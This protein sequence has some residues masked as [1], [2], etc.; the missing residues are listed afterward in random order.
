MAVYLW[1]PDDSPVSSVNP[2][3]KQGILGSCF[4]SREGGRELIIL[5]QEKQPIIFKCPHYKSQESYSEAS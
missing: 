5:Q 1:H 2:L 4:T 3:L